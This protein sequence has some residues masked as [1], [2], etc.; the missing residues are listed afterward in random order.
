MTE[1]YNKKTAGFIPADK[2]GN[3]AELPKIDMKEFLEALRDGI[4]GGSALGN[5]IERHRTPNE[6]KDEG[7]VGDPKKPDPK[8]CPNHS[9]KIS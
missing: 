6:Y 9:P 8:N 2:C 5:F 3:L 7:S 1:D 4:S